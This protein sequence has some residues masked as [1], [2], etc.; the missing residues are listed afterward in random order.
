MDLRDRLGRIRTAFDESNVTRRDYLRA[1][2]GVGTLTLPG[3]ALAQTSGDTGVEL[4][5]TYRF[6]YQHTPEDETVP[7]LIEFESADGLDGLDD[8]DVDAETTT[9]PAPASYAKL[10]PQVIQQVLATEESTL[11]GATRMRYSP[12][13]NPF[14]RLGYYPDSVFPTP[15]NSVDYI[16]YEQA[17]DGLRH[18]QKRHSDRISL[19]SVGESPGWYNVMD[20]E[21]ESQQIMVAEVTNNVTDG[22]SFSEKEKVVFSLSIHGDERSG[23]ETG[24][25]V[26]EDILKGRNE[27]LASMLD[28]LVLVFL[29]PNPDGW[30]APSPAYFSGD[31]VTDTDLVRVDAYRRTTG[32]MRDMN[33]QWPTIG[34]IDPTY[35]PAEPNGSD[36]TD[37][38]PDIDEDVPT[39]YSKYVPG[40]L[41]VVE[42]LRGYENLNYGADLHGMFDS[43]QFVLGLI[44][45]TEYDFEELHN[46]Y[47]MNQ[48]LDENITESIDPLIEEYGDLWEEL[49]TDIEEWYDEM[50]SDYEAAVPTEAFSYGTVYDTIDYTTTGTFASWFAQPE[51]L[52]GLGL[53]SM[54]PEMAF[55][56]R[57][58]E[59]V[60]W[61]PRTVETQV[62][63]YESF[64]ETMARQARRNITA[65]VNTGG[66]RT[67]Y[68]TTDA[69][70]RSS[71]S[72]SFANTTSDE[73]QVTVGV[74]P[75]NTESRTVSVNEGTTLRVGI[76]GHSGLAN[77]TLLDP[78]GE[79]AR[80][81]APSGT[82]G[83]RGTVL[84]VQD[85]AGDWTVE[86][87]NESETTQAQLELAI[88]TIEREGEGAPDPKE[89]L[90]YQ[91]RP[92]EVTP[93]AF[94]EEY[95]AC[96][97]EAN[98]LA[99]VTVGDVR[100]GALLDNGTPAFDNVVVIHDEG[101]DD[102]AY[103]SALE[104]YTAAGGNLVLT[105]TG[106]GH[107]GALGG[108][109]EG[110]T[111]NDVSRDTFVVAYFE[112]KDLDHPLMGDVREI[113]RELWRVAPLG[114]SIGDAAPMTL[115]GSDAFDEADG[116]VAATTDDLVAAGTLGGDDGDGT[117]QVIASL[118]PPATQDNLHPFGLHDYSVSFLGQTVL[119]NALGYRQR[120]F[121][122]GELIQ[123]FQPNE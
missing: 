54:S 111:S 113:Q 65:T 28:D 104:E 88:T 86:V 95:D 11:P 97:D 14:W 63:A 107:L 120:R 8:L 44:M 76:E 72:L 19:R 55:D 41:D 9:E 1:T 53:V 13:S 20:Y 77:T 99:P 49:A 61:S 6:I 85:A 70:R 87:T 73:Q 57:V 42:S 45:N 103:V 96:T 100:G 4:T 40:A 58:G 94:F 2:A 47:D 24:S 81:Y 69:L 90:G 32:T 60:E 84:T 67:A 26:I 29:Y 91:Q 5:E 48:R 50:G 123:T 39:Q 71:E 101:A 78:D 93:F 114:Y 43:E 56:N 35:Y 22:T 119:S 62:A 16:A 80:T 64:I 115:V 68:I 23:A 98:S 117:V 75:G 105:D 66:A 89:V 122:D 106:V 12:G 46:L 79:V 59:T 109:A 102:D 15:E 121:L 51:E 83:P 74:A 25:R 110:I 18:L 52:G 38:M 17:M 36:L 33:R 21:V 34:Y 3:Q 7:T 82:R 118:L 92:Y 37:D 112:D 30:V 116:T 108:P 31:E 10:P 27:E